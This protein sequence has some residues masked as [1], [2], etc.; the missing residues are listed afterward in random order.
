MTYRKDSNFVFTDLS[1]Y[2]TAA[3]CGFY[4]EVFGWETY[5]MGKASAE[6]G[7]RFGMDEVNYHIATLGSKAT[8]GIF[9]MPPFFQ[10]I[11]MPPFWMSYLAVDDIDS[12]V[13]RAKT[14]EGVIIDV[15]PTPFGDGIMALIRDPLGAGFTCYDGP[16]IES[17]GDGSEYGRMVWNELITSSIDKVEH[18][19]REVLGLNVVPDAEFQGTRAKLVNQQG[20]VVAG[21]QEVDASLRGEKV[22]WVPFFSV[23]SLSAFASRASAAGGQMLSE[24]QGSALFYDNT[25]AAFGVTETGAEYSDVRPWYRR[26]F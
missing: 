17:K 14:I 9:D 21:I 25:K 18:F 13:A 1:S 16:S 4:G 8:A 11:K 15:E 6:P 7:D 26:F 20:E 3:S 5:D 10:K 23:D 12:V 19:Y 2:D 22:Y 24:D